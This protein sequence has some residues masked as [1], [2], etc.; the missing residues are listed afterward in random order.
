MILPVTLEEE[1]NF[2][3]FALW[4]NYDHFVLIDYF[5]LFLHFLFSLMKFAL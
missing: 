4:L 2:L 1:L 5:S 3:Y